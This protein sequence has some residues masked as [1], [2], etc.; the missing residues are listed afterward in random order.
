M[1]DGEEM[2][3]VGAF[4]PSRPAEMRADALSA[5]FD[6]WGALID[7]VERVKLPPRQA[8]T[9]T[10]HY[11]SSALARIRPLLSSLTEVQSPTSSAPSTAC[12]ACAAAQGR[13]RV[14]VSASS[15]SR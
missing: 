11:S 10:R 7:L 5:D 14:R 13:A 4:S 8:H 6:D 1:A 15:R 12:P 3:P 9:I 2:L